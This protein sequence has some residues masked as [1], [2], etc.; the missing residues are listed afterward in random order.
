MKLSTA[1]VALTFFTAEAR[2]NRRAQDAAADAAV[3]PDAALDAVAA[4]NA[5]SRRSSSCP[6]EEE[7]VKGTVHI[8][9]NDDEPER[10]IGGFAFEWNSSDESVEFISAMGSSFDRDACNEYEKQREQ[11]PPKTILFCPMIPGQRASF[12][13]TDTFYRRGYCN[14]DRK[15]QGEDEITEDRKGGPGIEFYIVTPGS[16]TRRALGDCTGRRALEERNL[17]GA[18]TDITATLQCAQFGCGED[19]VRDFAQ[20]S[21]ELFGYAYSPLGAEYSFDL[22][23]CQ[24]WDFNCPII[25][26]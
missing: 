5:G 3:V 24:I 4:D 23:T 17:N 9:A 19:F 15:L 2:V 16:G 1:I 10:D 6:C 18:F 22:E 21:G 13:I 20:T 8:V 11:G 12:D 14:E 25:A 26:K 7:V